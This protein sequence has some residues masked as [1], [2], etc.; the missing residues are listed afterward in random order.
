MFDRQA[1]FEG[2]K[3]DLAPTLEKASYEIN[4]EKKE[5]EFFQGSRRE[6]RLVK[7]ENAQLLYAFSIFPLL[8]GAVVF[9]TRRRK[10]GS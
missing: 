4:L 5:G 10:L 1:T 9:V 7:K 6:V 3:L 8:V 2:Y